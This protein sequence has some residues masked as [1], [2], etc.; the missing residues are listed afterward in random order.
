MSGYGKPGGMVPWGE[1]STAT[2]RSSP[3]A[4]SDGPSCRRLPH[5]PQRSSA[6]TLVRLLA[7]LPLFRWTRCGEIAS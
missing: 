5:L 3:P 1:T 2:A 4:K 7:A 6:A